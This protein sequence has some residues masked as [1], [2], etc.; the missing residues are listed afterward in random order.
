MSTA[1]YSQM[2]GMSKGFMHCAV[3]GSS[4]PYGLLEIFPE[5]RCVAVEPTV[6]RPTRWMRDPSHVP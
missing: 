5:F 6:M 3:S 2:I 1:L 4:A